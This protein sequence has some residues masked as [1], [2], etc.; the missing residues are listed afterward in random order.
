MIVPLT[1]R[2]DY[3]YTSLSQAIVQFNVH[4]FR[5][6]IFAFYYTKKNNGFIFYQKIHL[7]QDLIELKLEF[8]YNAQIALN[9]LFLLPIQTI[10]GSFT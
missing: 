6:L 1:K 8:N 2:I 4:P 7:C 5:I 9:V 10:G 3:T